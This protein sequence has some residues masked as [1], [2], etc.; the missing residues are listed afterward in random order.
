[1][2][3]AG[4]DGCRHGWLGV[5]LLDGTFHAAGLFAT[6]HEAR[7]AWPHA[8][9]LGVDIPIGLPVDRLR[10]A[11]LAARL[12]LGA[13]AAA[14][15]FLTPPRPVLEAPTYEEASRRSRDLLHAGISKQAY[16]LRDKILEVD[17]PAR[18]DERIHEVHPEI[19]F[20]AM[21]SEREPLRH[22]KKTWSGLM[23]RR[24]RLAV[25]GIVIPDDLGDSGRA[26]AD[27]VLDAGATAWSAL[28][29]ARG[30]A[31]PLPDPPERLDGR[32]V[33]IWC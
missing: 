30:E 16:A 23:E 28:R 18:Q 14:S 27:D 29:I 9:I 31:K 22:S 3:V 13:R 15:V 10:A 26:A 21:A 20:R 11:D 12:A 5:A 4:F 32:D 1:V 24:A 19:S 7:E 33:A 8:R 6:F 17:L 2:I 25:E